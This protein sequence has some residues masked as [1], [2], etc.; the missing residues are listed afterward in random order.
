VRDL[1][2]VGD[3]HREVRGA[4]PESIARRPRLVKAGERDQISSVPRQRLTV[5]LLSAGDR[6]CVAAAKVAQ[7]GAQRRKAQIASSEAFR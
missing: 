5:A 7:I 2:A 3:G 1:C 4:V 6:D